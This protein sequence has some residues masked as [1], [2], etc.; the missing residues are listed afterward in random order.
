MDT[1][2]NRNRQTYMTGNSLL[3]CTGGNYVNYDFLAHDLDLC[4]IQQLS[5]V[6]DRQP[7]S[8]EIGKLIIE[9]GM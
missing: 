1:Q 4:M 6:Y 5:L 8:L 7:S 3:T 9:P 2:T